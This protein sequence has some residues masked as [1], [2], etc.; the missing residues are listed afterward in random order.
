MGDDFFQGEKV[1][2]YEVVTRLSIGGMAELFLARLDGPGGFQKLVALKRILPDVRSDERFVQMFLDEARLSAELNHPN[3]GQVFDLGQ[4]PTG[5]LYLAMEF[6]SGKDF[7]AV[8]RASSRQERRLELP[9]VARIIRDVCLGLH[10]AHTHTDVTGTPRPVIHRDVA[11]KNV[12]LTFDGFVKVIDFGIAHAAGRK[13]RTQTGVVK[14]TPNYMAP[15]QLVAEPPTPATDVFAVGVMLHEALTGEP[16]FDGGAPLARFQ[17]PRPPSQSNPA[18]PAAL[19]EV[20]LKALSPEPKHRFQTARELARA[21]ADV[22]PQPADEEEL[23]SLMASLFP[24][25]RAALASLTE[26]A[27]DPRRSNA[28]LS[29]LARKA[30]DLEPTARPEA[31]PERGT[32]KV[33]R[34]PAATVPTA[35][36]WSPL[37]MVAVGAGGMA[38]LL[39]TFALLDTGPEPPRGPTPPQPIV[40]PAATR[41][42]TPAPAAEAPAARA[43][44]PTSAELAPRLAPTPLTQAERLL[45]DADAAIERGDLNAA[46][47]LLRACKVND[48]PCPQATRLLAQ[49]PRERL[50]ARMLS[51]AEQALARGDVDKAGALLASAEETKLLR[52]RWGED[53]LARQA[54][55]QAIVTANATRPTSTNARAETE[56]SRLLEESK[57]AKKEKRYGTA[58]QLL[59]RCLDLEPNNS[60]CIVGLASVHA[61]KGGEEQNPFDNERARLL[62]QRFL[63]VAPPDDK[64]IPRVREIL[65]GHSRY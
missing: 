44:P 47:A 3:L 12:M 19:D 34:A 46:E 7:G 11:P 30:L 59:K 4:E 57:E 23:A 51:D 62:Y 50:Y 56:A 64:R 53:N 2:R 31:A 8:L 45:A 43:A 10:A 37:A 33:V 58:I 20:C 29:Q 24:G 18:V 22:V 27:R 25:Q 60:D 16:L 52:K 39:T 15:E 1:G 13:T 65:A 21:L 17:L 14:G 36:R 32:R 5:E 49:L 6:I 35:R 9:V 41:P 55:V 26:T 40:L 38:L 48:V 54:A 63:Q 28:Q 42:A 61:Q